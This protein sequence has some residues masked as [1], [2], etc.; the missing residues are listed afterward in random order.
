M[1]ILVVNNTNQTVS[2]S[3]GCVIAK[4]DPIASSR[5][6]SVNTLVKNTKPGDGKGGTPMWMSHLII[7]FLKKNKDLFA[8]AD[9]ELG[10]FPIS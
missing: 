6:E 5:I 9:S 4:V 7:K 2:L 10:E 3:K 8:S 1:P